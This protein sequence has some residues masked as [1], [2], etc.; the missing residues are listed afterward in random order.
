MGGT[1]QCRFSSLANG[2]SATVQIVGQPTQRG[3]IVNR[4]R[5][6]SAV[7]DPNPANDAPEISTRVL[8]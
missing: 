8:P 1:I 7:L 6:F 2:A 3:T 4:A 5:V